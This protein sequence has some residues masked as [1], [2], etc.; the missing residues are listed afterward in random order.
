MNKGFESPESG[1]MGKVWAVGA[2]VRAVADFLSARFNPVAVQGELSGFSR[3]ASGH[4]YFSLKDDAGQVRCAMFR[5]PADQLD[6]QPRDGQRVEAS[7]KLDVYGPRGDLQLIV[8][9]LQP[10][11]QG[12]L[13]EQFLRIK[14]QLESEGLFDPDRKRPLPRH[15]ASVAVVTS[16]GAAALRDVATALRRRAPHVDVTIHPASVQG[17]Q[18]PQEICLA[19]EAAYTRFKRTGQGE[20]LLLVRGGGSLEDLWAFN[21][22]QVVR[23]VALAPMPLVCGVGHETDFTL[24]DFA[25]DLRA[26]TPTAA[27]EICAPPRDQGLAELDYLHERL[28]DLVIGSVDRRTQRLDYLAQRMGRPSLRLHQGAQALTT[29]D[30]RMQTSR[31][32]FLQAARNQTRALADALPKGVARVLEMH[33]RQLRAS[34]TVLSMLDPR[35]VLDRGFAYLSDANDQT[36]V[37][38][39]QTHAGQRITAHLADGTVDLTVNRT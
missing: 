18:A 29:L 15:P 19:L 16:L 33:A 17:L 30:H 14:A 3:A 9:R 23:A 35:N 27:A 5:R 37:R 10:L 36:I 26:P 12:S 2:L 1:A 20:V 25:A 38:A 6:F 4:C 39:A 22:P 31:K 8:E 32:A 21:D 28:A 11:G 34:E 13:F 7:G 24:A